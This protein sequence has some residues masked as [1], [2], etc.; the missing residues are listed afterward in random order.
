[1][2]EWEV[3]ETTGVSDGRSASYAREVV[4]AGR[5]LLWHAGKEF[6]GRPD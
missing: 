1:M 5:V 6:R 3:P 4:G 2:D